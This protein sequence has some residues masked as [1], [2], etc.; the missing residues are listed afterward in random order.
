MLA[1]VVLLLLMGWLACTTVMALLP[2]PSLREPQQRAAT[3]ER[4]AVQSHASLP[5]ARLGEAIER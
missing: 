4:Q 5:P 2:D 1:T 3:P